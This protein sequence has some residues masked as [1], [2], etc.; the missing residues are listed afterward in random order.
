M[1]SF[2]KIPSDN[3][4]RNIDLD[5]LRIV[6]TQWSDLGSGP[7]GAKPKGDPREFNVD[8][9]G[10]TQKEEL[11]IPLMWLHNTIPQSTLA[12]KQNLNLSKPLGLT[13]PIREIQTTEEKHSRHW[14]SAKEPE[15]GK[16]SDKQSVFVSTRNYKKKAV[17]K[18]IA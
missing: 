11:C 17:V 18:S 10:L 2:R 7:H 1:F 5:Y 9:L 3:D 15:S 16:L 4:G 13:L 12:K 8:G 6:M 14:G